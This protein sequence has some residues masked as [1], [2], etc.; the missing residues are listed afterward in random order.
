MKRFGYITG[1]ILSAIT[2]GACTSVGENSLEDLQ[3][4]GSVDVGVA[5]ERPYGYEESG[6]E[7][8]VTGASVEVA[9][10]VLT[11]LGIDEIEGNVVDFDALING[12]NSRNFDIVTAGVYVTPERCENAIF[13]E[14][15]YRIGEGLAVAPGNP[16][17]ITSY[18]DIADN[19]DIS[20]TVMSGAI[21]LEYL[22]AMGVDDSQIDQ[23]SSITDNI[24][25]LTAGRTDAITMTDLTLRTALEDQDDGNFEIVEDFEQPVIDG[26]E[27][28]GYGAA[29]FHPDDEEF[30]DAYNEVLAELK[31]SG[32]VLEIMEPF[33]FTEDNMVTDMTTEELCAG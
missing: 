14:P 22:R 31:E 24:S 8:G 3:E 17:D 33:G 13:S 10:A 11:E 4:R 7:G 12:V 6:E 28:Y 27:V 19:P 30:R 15:D 20:V 29:V 23:V 5:N 9:R 21:E 16:H 32:R 1:I 26:E 2:L 18:Q 25:A